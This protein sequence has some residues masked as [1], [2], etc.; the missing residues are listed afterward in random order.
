MA[1]Y[2]SV[3][4]REIEE[5]YPDFIAAYARYIKSQNFTNDYLIDAEKKVEIIAGEMSKYA[6]EIGHRRCIDLAMAVGRMLEAVGVWN[7]VVLG[8]LS[9]EVAGDESTRKII[10][11]FG[12][13]DPG[14][15]VMGHAWI[16]APP[17]SI[18]DVSVA[19]QPWGERLEALIPRPVLAKEENG[20]PADIETL[21]DHDL[22]MWNLMRGV[23]LTVADVARSQSG[24]PE[25]FR[26]FPPIDIVRDGIKLRYIPTAFSACAEGFSDM[27]ADGGI[28]AE[29]LWLDRVQPLLD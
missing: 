8:A 14:A 22:L 6:A 19:Y 26:D 13:M 4:F 17:F 5:R 25:L 21:V 16:C 29:R 9:V 27:G 3:R 11:A 24:L 18:V 28:P 15:T 12:E 1:F 2:D 20:S 10:H 23:R 7:Y